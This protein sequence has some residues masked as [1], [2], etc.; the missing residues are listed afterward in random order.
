M[1]LCLELRIKKETEDKNREL[2]A[3]RVL[4]N[5]GKLVYNIRGMKLTDSN[6]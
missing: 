6:R 3:R 5:A 4:I 1:A 2:Y